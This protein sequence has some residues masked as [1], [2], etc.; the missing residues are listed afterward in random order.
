[1]AGQTSL[2]WCVKSINKSFRLRIYSYWLVGACLYSTHTSYYVQ[3]F[4][5]NWRKEKRRTREK[6]HRR[7]RD[8][9]LTCWLNIYYNI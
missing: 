3:I 9:Q 1:M 7:R 8:T 6:N 4:S 2:K 5:T